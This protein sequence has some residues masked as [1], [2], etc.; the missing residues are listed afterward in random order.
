MN[1]TTTDDTVTGGPAETLGDRIR[2][3]RLH[4]GL[5]VEA[6]ARNMGVETASLAA[7]ES[8]ERQPRANR[9]NLLSGMLDVTLAW[10]LDGGSQGSPTARNLDI[11]EMRGELERVSQQLTALAGVVDSLRERLSDSA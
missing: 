10:L 7:W 9:L 2:E 1:S 11:E 5:S 4:R 3:A 6:L 8:G